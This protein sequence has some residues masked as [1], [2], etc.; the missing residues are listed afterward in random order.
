MKQNLQTTVLEVDAHTILQVPRIEDSRELFDVVEA[1][2][3]HLR[4]FLFWVDYNTRPEGSELFITTANQ[5]ARDGSELHL[6]IYHYGKIVGTVGFHAIDYINSATEIGYWLA[7]EHEGKGLVTLSCKALIRFAFVTL[8]LHRI[9]LRS[10]CHNQKSK[11]IAE[12]LGFT[13]EGVA[14]QSC[15]LTSGFHDME[16]YSLLSTD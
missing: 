16:V 10:A 5:K 2:R 1:N 9:E 11:Q 6:G 13:K 4:R 8:G 12:R 15:K 7:K 14:R 3:E